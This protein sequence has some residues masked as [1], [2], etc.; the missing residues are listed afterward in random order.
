M[1]VSK[2]TPSRRQA[3]HLGTRFCGCC[4]FSLARASPYYFCFPGSSPVTEPWAWLS[5][6][7][8]GQGEAP[9]PAVIDV[10]VVFNF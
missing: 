8:L 10:M 6:A 3:G 9:K 1:A 7:G 4:L 2:S 5:W